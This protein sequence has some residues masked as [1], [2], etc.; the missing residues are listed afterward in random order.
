MTCSRKGCGLLWARQ[1]LPRKGPWAALGKGRPGHCGW[2]MSLS[3]VPSPGMTTNNIPQVSLNMF[4]CWG[5]VELAA[6]FGAGRQLALHM[7]GLSS[8]PGQWGLVGAPW[9]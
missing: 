7:C 5:H 2:S 9:A 6:K 8:S 4:L 1:G 3:I